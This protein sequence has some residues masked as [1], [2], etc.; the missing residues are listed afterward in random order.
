MGRIVRDQSVLISGAGIAGPTLAYWLA[1]YGFKP[2]LVERAPRF[3][4]SGYVIDL[5]GLGYDIAEKMGLLPDLER[6]AYRVD[7]LRFVNDRG[8]R[9]GGFAVDI[10]RNMTSGRYIS[11]PRSDLVKAIY[12]T[13]ES[14]CE[15]VF[16]DSVAGI[17]NTRDSVTV[18]FERSPCR[19]FDLVVGADG[20]HSAVRR[21]VFGAE[22]QFEKYLGYAM[23]AFEARGYRPRDEGAYVS[24]GLPGKQASRFPLR[25]DRTLFLIV[26]QAQKH[27]LADHHDMRAQKA[28]LHREFDDAGWE[29]A[30]IL[31]ALDR[32]EELYF[33]T[34]SQIRMDRWS[35][36]R[37]A[38]V[39]DSAFAPSLLAGQGSAL[40]MTAAYVFA[41]ELTMAEGQYWRAFER[42]ECV[43]R[44]FIDGKQK[45]AEQFAGSFTP[46]SEFG[47]L[48]RNQLSKAF[49]FAFIAKFLVGRG[50][51]DRLTL[52]AYPLPRTQ[53]HADKSQ[54]TKLVG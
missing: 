14:R 54:E 37:V 47:L 52:P 2:T 51:L 3:R 10:F 48:I 30:Q 34:V 53:I 39:G 9:V 13:I 19:A 45:A 46:R 15:I 41:A 33:D 43:L 11:L 17:E 32:T 21:V 38:L 42:Y 29:C 50:L 26:F 20:L 40:A 35:C 16:D 5:W 4:E 24:Y 23:A 44:E 25:D 7:E 22:S 12:R 1:G 6:R 18:K 36:G 49:R 8:K 27:L 31:G 28:L